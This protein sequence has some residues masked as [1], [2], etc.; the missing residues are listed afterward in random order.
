[1][2]ELTRLMNQLDNGGS[3]EQANFEENFNL[4]MKAMPGASHSAQLHQA[5]SKVPVQ[6]RGAVLQAFSA[7]SAS[8]PAISKGVSGGMDSGV[9]HGLVISSVGDL[10]L[11]V[12]RS[13]VKTGVPLPFILFGA[14]DLASEYN[15]TLTALIAQIPQSANLTATS[16]TVVSGNVVFSYTTTN[17]GGGTDTVTVTNLGN[18]NY[19]TFLANMTT[20][21]FATKYFLLSI[22]DETYNLSQFGQILLFGELSALG[23]TKANQ[24][25]IRS[26]TNSWMFRKDRVE[27]LLQEQEIVPDFSFAMNIVAV[28]G[29]AI[30]FDFFMSRRFK[31][32]NIRG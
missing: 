26:R 9:V 3:F 27:V 2:D 30:G 16:V 28:D 22:S 6:H 12:T 29:F 17:A 15:S 11:T 19:R 23:M 8:N 13:G 32:Q 18:L 4:I 25:V 5:I 20:N 21:F 14:N 7:G 1:M 31:P 24:L 10:N